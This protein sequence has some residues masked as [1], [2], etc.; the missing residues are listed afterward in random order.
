ADLFLFEDSNSNGIFDSEDQQITSSDNPMNQNETINF[1]ATAGTYF[2]QVQR[3][4]VGSNGRLSYDLDFSLAEQ[5]P[6]EP[7]TEPPV[8]APVVP[9][10]YQAFDPGQV[11]ALNSNAG[12]DHV[13]YLDFDGHVT[14]GTDW[15][16]EYGRINSSA[17]DTDGNAAAFSRSER[18]M[19]WQVWQRVAEDFAPFDVN[20][21]TELPSADRLV[22]SGNRDTRWG[23]RTVIGDSDWYD[24]SGVGVAYLNSFSDR[25]DVPVFVFSDQYA[26]RQQEIGLAE[27]IS[28]EVGHALGLEHDGQRGGDEY[29]EGHGS[30][31]RSWAPIMG[32]SDNAR[33]TQWS[34]GEY[35]RADNRQD[36]LDIITGQS[37]GFGYREDDHGD[38]VT[39]A[40]AL[41][42]R[43]G[44]VETYGV[45]EKDADVDMFEINSSTGI[46]DLAVNAF[47]RGANLDIRAQLLNAAGRVLG[48]YAPSGSLSATVR[49]T[50]NPGQ[51]FLSVEGVGNGTG[52]NGY[53]GY[54]SI[55]QYS[56]EGSIA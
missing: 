28:H 54:A 13:I 1:A 5:P 22:R 3:Y 29:Y 6:V 25:S 7:P 43:N 32:F 53:T 2:A 45:I 10:T 40:S 9:E 46:I 19:I 31:S 52:V 15:N 17:Y 4:E 55:G 50:L 42:F 41:S 33:V 34:R 11:F 36:D 51:Y 8:L 27:T 21:T 12:A 23:V 39:N 37:N 18:Q 16:D 49:Q 47:E 30:G 44:T 48:S 26:V 35:S 38:S 56:I 14:T 20:V 24:D